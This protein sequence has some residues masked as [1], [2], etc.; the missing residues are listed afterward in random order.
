MRDSKN[1]RRFYLTDST[2]GVVELAKGIE[3][4]MS[5]CVV[6]ESSVE[7]SGPIARPTMVYPVFFFV[8]AEK[9]K[10]GDAAAL[11]KEE[12]KVH[13]R[14]FLAWLKAKYDKEMQENINGDFARLNLEDAYVDYL[15]IGPL[16]NGWYAVMVQLEREEPLNLCV[17]EDLYDDDCE[18]EHE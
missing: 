14:N 11:A 18:C 16:E 12:A 5:P 1:N 3:N 4:K 15:T 9:Q 13:A 8:R 6:M 10:D 17:D 2:T 7:G